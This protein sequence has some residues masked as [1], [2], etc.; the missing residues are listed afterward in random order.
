MGCAKADPALDLAILLDDACEA[1]SEE[2]DLSL[3]QLRGQLKIADDEPAANESVDANE[4]DD[5]DG[6]G[7][8]GKGKGETNAERREAQDQKHTAQREA[9][10]K[11][12][13][14]KDKIQEEKQKKVNAA[15]AAQEE[16]KK[17]KEGKG[18]KENSGSDDSTD[19]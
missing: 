5:S 3:R 9:Q 2:C 7:K 18:T 6:H 1:G 19:T 13:E 8:E 4:G 16:K 10:E 14:E 15:R 17:E 11:K 12:R